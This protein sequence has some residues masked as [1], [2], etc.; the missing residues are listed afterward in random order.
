MVRPLRI[1]YRGILSCGEPRPIAQGYFL[2]GQGSKS[3]GHWPF[4]LSMYERAAAKLA[5]FRVSSQLGLRFQDW[6]LV[7]CEK[8]KNML[9][10]ERHGSRWDA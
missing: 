6:M 4:T 10:R 7:F 3:I 2:G 8:R 9:V 5:P 1:E